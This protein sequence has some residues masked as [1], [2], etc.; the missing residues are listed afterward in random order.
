MNYKIKSGEAVAIIVNLLCSKMFLMTPYLFK[1]ELKAGSIFAYL[2]FFTVAL[3]ILLVFDK[4]KG[5]INPY[6]GIITSILILAITGSFIT[7]YA[8]SLKTLFFEETPIFIIY[9]SLYVI[10]LFGAYSGMTAL[11]KAS[12]LFVPVIFIISIIL[13][14][15]AIIGGNKFNLFPILGSGLFAIAG[16]SFKVLSSLF[17]LSILFFMPSFLENK[18]DFKK[19]A[20]KSIG[21][22][23]IIFTA[24]TLSCL[25]TLH[26]SLPE[27][28]FSPIFLI[29]RQ[30]K[31][32]TY[33]QHPDSLFLI[34]Y[35]ISAFLYL[36]TMLFF[37]S[38]IMASS[39]R[40]NEKH[41]ILFFSIIILIASGFS[42]YYEMYQN[43]IYMFLWAI[44][45]V[46]PFIPA[47]RRKK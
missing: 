24:I 1:N 37:S 12:A 47:L 18:N 20:I 44:P 28:F 32:G 36:S 23:F 14:I 10:M 30:V 15:P 2:I 33:F 25:A 9:M 29:M 35:L 42:E 19:I 11:S 7:Q 4:F 3:L 13:T 8:V 40:H 16:S 46:L 26:L 38:K 5:N 21:Y 43:Y 6:T 39:T 31:I 41:L 27:G 34:F 22:T 45:F 17:E